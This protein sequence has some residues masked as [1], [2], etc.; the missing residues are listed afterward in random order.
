MSY[1][2][3]WINS[4]RLKFTKENQHAIFGAKFVTMS[5]MKIFFCDFF[6]WFFKK[7]F[8][9][10]VVIPPCFDLWSFC[11]SI[12]ASSSPTTEA[13]DAFCFLWCSN[14]LQSVSRL[15]WP[16]CKLAAILAVVE[17]IAQF[18]LSPWWITPINMINYNFEFVSFK[19]FE[20][21]CC[22]STSFWDT[23]SPT[24]KGSEE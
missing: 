2:W 1:I 19:T 18:F 14:S 4:Q 13:M 21:F 16:S 7:T 24:N 11:I 20:N 23:A 6:E 5:I 3:P 9:P 10:S 22:L 15:M 17:F 12:L 8:L